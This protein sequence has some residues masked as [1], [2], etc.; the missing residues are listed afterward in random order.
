MKNI[1]FGSV[2]TDAFGS[3]TVSFTGF[4]QPMLILPTIKKAD[5]DKNIASFF[6]YTELIDVINNTYKFYLGATS[7]Y[8]L[9]AT[10][11]TQEGKEIS[12]DNA[13]QST[14]EKYTATQVGFSTTISK[15]Y[16][17]KEAPNYTHY[18][19][20]P[21]YKVHLK[22]ITNGVEK[23][24]SSKAYTCSVEIDLEGIGWFNGLKFIP[25]IKPKSLD[26]SLNWVYQYDSRASVTYKIEIEITQPYLEID[27]GRYV[28]EKKES[29]GDSTNIYIIDHY[30]TLP[31]GK[32]LTLS[33]GH[34]NNFSVTGNAETS[35]ITDAFGNGTVNFIAMEIE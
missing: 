27:A 15:G 34:F 5:F 1:R 8:H 35:T 21:S 20:I 6:C 18:Y 7:E 12:F 28:Q 30:A 9:P 14:W 29:G 25:T 17:K 16:S 3:G 24:I 33:S 10:S 26:S 23:I 32:Y 11:V 22:T 4:K 19:K 31:R 2:V 13:L